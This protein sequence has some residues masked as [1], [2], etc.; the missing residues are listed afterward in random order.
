MI[1]M[2]SPSSYEFYNPRDNPLRERKEGTPL[3]RVFITEKKITVYSKMIVKTAKSG[4]L[5]EKVLAQQTFSLHENRNGTKY[6]KRFNKSPGG[7]INDTSLE[8]AIRTRRTIDSN[9]LTGNIS[10]PCRIFVEEAILGWFGLE[11][12]EENTMSL[13]QGKLLFPALKDDN[14]PKDAALSTSLVELQASVSTVTKAL[15][16]NDSWN[17]FILDL[18]HKT[19][20]TMEDVS[21]V[22]SHPNELLPITD[23]ELPPL[24]VLYT[25]SREALLNVVSTFTP[26]D[27]SLIRFMFKN[28]PPDSRI[29]ALVTML[30]LSRVHLECF[31]E[32]RNFRH[33]SRYHSLEPALKRVPSKRRS[34]LAEKLLE[35]FVGNRTSVQGP[36]RAVAFQDNFIVTQLSHT[37]RY[38]FAQE[39]MEPKLRAVTTIEDIDSRFIELFGVPLS[40]K[41][42]PIKFHKK[43]DLTFCSLHTFF[44]TG[45]VPLYGPDLF[46][47]L[48][49]LVG[50][51]RPQDKGAS[52]ELFPVNGYV[53]EDRVFVPVSGGLYSLDDLMQIIENGVTALDKILVKMGRE[54]TPENRTAFLNFRHKE[55]KFKNTWKYYD[56][57]VTDVTKILGLKKAKVT[58][59]D[60]IQ[61][62]NALPDEMFNELISLACGTE[63]NEAGKWNLL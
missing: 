49:A 14:F 36:D 4:V 51:N 33:F 55:R 58:R 30:A 62:Y 3:Y 37:F 57:G 21:I 63:Y 52:A 47:S 32:D 61:T 23:M 56:L 38:W 16:E 60:D 43:D 28:L 59:K 18:G 46:V 13:V 11:R 40:G 12:T 41:D 9:L 20:H 2:T 54:A 44:S 34:E 25:Q 6:I 8:A 27:R 39:I 31:K 22:K 1:D 50:K 35:S 7:S 10:Y 24:S 5:F 42:A 53:G 29:E 17:D 15:R 45:G 26:H 19:V 48:C